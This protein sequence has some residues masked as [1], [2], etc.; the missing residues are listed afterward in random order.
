Y[1]AEDNCF[2]RACLLACSDNFTIADGTV[3]ALGGDTPGSDALD[4]IGALFHH[5]A[6]A[7]AY[8]RIASQFFNRSVIVGVEQE[9][10]PAHLIGAVVGTIPSAHTAVVDHVIEPFRTVH[11]GSHRTNALARRV[12]AL[13]AGDGLEVDAWIRRIAL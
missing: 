5:A 2:G 11:G 8:V 6:A 12:L 7:N 10:E 13:H 9:V 1:I 3:F 4:A